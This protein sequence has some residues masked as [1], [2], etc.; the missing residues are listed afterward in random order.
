MDDDHM[1]YIIE[2]YRAP[3][4]VLRCY[5]CQK[6]DD[7]VAAHCPNKNDPVCFKCGQ[8][9][10]YNPNC[11]NAIQCPHCQGDHM[12]GS[13]NC[14]TKIAKRQEKNRKRMLNSTNWVPP[15]A[16]QQRPNACLDN[17]GQHLLGN[18]TTTRPTDINQID[19]ADILN[20]INN[21]MVAISQQQHALNDKF[22]ALSAKLNIHSTEMNHI[23]YVIDEILCP[24]IKEVSSQVSTQAKAQKKQKISPLYDKLAEYMYKKSNIDANNSSSVIMMNQAQEVSNKETDRMTTDES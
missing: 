11:Q 23:N 24:L 15:P 10:Q 13:P 2:P 7:H 5:I 17:T 20:K 4:R 12:A 16:T 22:T 14:P 9:H 18:A 3:T 6:Y 21:T 8:H 1:S 19:I